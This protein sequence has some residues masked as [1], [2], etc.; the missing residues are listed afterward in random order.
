MTNRMEKLQRNFLWGG[1]GDKFKFHLVRWDTIC[2]PDQSGG[3]GVRNLT[4]F[5][6]ALLRKWLWRYGHKRN[7]LWRWVIDLKYSSKVRG[8]CKNVVRQPYGV[9]L[10]RYIGWGWDI[11]SQLVKFEVGDGMHI[12]FWYG[13]RGIS[14]T[15]SYF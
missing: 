2:Q 9:S 11:F 6:G 14:E 15:A 5:T 13:T 12:R 4:I 7:A 1:M 10:W 3:L 8:W